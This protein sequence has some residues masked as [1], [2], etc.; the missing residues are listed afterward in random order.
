MY[1]SLTAVNNKVFLTLLLSTI[2]LFFVG[3]GF[4]YVIMKRY[5]F[6]SAI[7]FTSK[8]KDAIK[9][10]ARSTALV[11]GQTVKISMFFASFFGWSLSCLLLVPLFYVLPY[12]K[13][14][15]F[16]YYNFVIGFKPVEI[17]REKPIILHSLKYKRA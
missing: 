8:E 9:I 7:I 10:L 16:N 14:S 12:K 17:A 5:S 2:I 11:E 13:I 4:L 1:F 6:T 3:L 15:Q